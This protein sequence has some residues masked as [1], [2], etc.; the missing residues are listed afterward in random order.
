MLKMKFPIVILCLGMLLGGD[1]LMSPGYAQK[2][3]TSYK[4][5][6]EAMKRQDWNHAI[7]NFELCLKV[8]Y[9][10]SKKLR[11]KGVM[12]IEYY[13]NR[14]IGIC[15]F[16]IGD[17]E[18]AKLHLGASLRQASTKRARNFLNRI[19]SGN[20]PKTNIQP[21]LVA[22]GNR[23]R[24][25]LRRP[26]E[27]AQLAVD[28][29]FIEPS[30]NGF[31]DAEESG[32]IVIDV[33]NNGRGNAFDLQVK[34]TPQTDTR[35]VT[36]GQARIINRLAPGRQ[37]SVVIPISTRQNILSKQV[38][39]KVEV[40]EKNGFD[41]DPVS[42][43]TFNTRALVP[44][45]L[46]IDDIGIDDSS[47]NS[48]IEPREIVDI[49]ARIK[50]N[51]QGEARFVEA[52]VQVGVNVFV[53][54]DSKTEFTL[55]NLGPGQF[56]DVTFTVFTNSKATSVPINIILKEVRGRYDKTLPLDLPFNKPQRKGRDLVV[57]TV[58]TTEVDDFET[59]SLSI[60]VDTNI[61]KS[62][63][64]NQDAIAIILGVEQYKSIPN[65]TFAKRDASI[66]KEYAIRVLGVPNSKNN[67]YFKTDYE[68]T[69]GEFLK[70]FTGNSWLKKRVQPNSDV[71]IYFA[72]H[73]A[74]DVKDK[75]PYLIPSDGDANYPSQTGFNLNVL[76]EEL[77][78]LNARSIC[79]FL[80]ACFSGG[81]RENTMLLADSRP[82]F[83]KIENPTLQSD[84]L[85]AF[86][87][88]DSH[89]ISSGYPAKKHG[90]FTYFLL[91]GLRGD[92]DK[93]YDKSI[94]IAEL[95]EYLVANVRKTAGFLDREQTPQVMGMNKQKQLV[96]Y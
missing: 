12:F 91:K 80:D 90:L 34:L 95:E 56:K 54:P 19:L 94:T 41:L 31:L 73:G 47:Q 39:L 38:K 7:K 59:S 82:V 79:V 46:V 58:P 43:I 64:Y 16:H 49:T 21:P 26:T 65:V 1:S 89:E 83:I 86:S 3:Y 5:G 51:G 45:E 18:K 71:Y 28:L 48:Q 61:P 9:K 96:K 27:P 85:V 69:K 36:I 29:F 35:G 75:T 88:T 4:Y 20:Y 68:V 84:K 92:A 22:P 37:E 66:F 6:L 50:N 8:R 17:I 52:T 77:S 53:T 33:K 32:K 76:Y 40:S 14:E 87:A 62:R 55:G 15:Y 24:E 42:F 13:V 78:K 30:N 72:G 11:A 57:S 70:L 74:P 67:I 25:D 23:P 60:D 81:T 63:N 10:D 2:W 44:P 93:N